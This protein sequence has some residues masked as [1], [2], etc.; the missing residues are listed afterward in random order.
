[1]ILSFLFF[2]ALPCSEVRIFFASL[3]SA[4]NR[5]PPDLVGRLVLWSI[6]FAGS[7]G[8]EQTSPGRFVPRLVLLP[9]SGG[10]N[11]RAP[12]GLK[13]PLFHC[14]LITV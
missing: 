5:G 1:M 6:K 10:E 13:S 11:C 4:Q 14:G 8:A 3:R 7:V 2:G 9:W 12:K